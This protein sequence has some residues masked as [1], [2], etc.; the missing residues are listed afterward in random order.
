MSYLTLIR[1]HRRLIG[2]GFLLALFSSF[3][4]T[5]FISIFNADIRSAYGLSQGGFGTIYSLATLTSAALVIR[6][7]GLIDR[8][9]LRRYSLGILG[10]LV[11]AMAYMSLMPALS[12]LLLF[13][14]ILLLRFFG[15]GLT[16]QASVIVVSRYIEGGRGKAIALSALGYSTGEALLPTLTVALVGLL[17]W[18]W[19]WGA[20]ALVLAAVALPLVIWLLRGQERR[21]AE[22]MERLATAPAAAGRLWGRRAVLRDPFFQLLLP[23]TLALGFINTGIFFCQVPLVEAKGWSLGDFAAAVAV[24]AG[25]SVATS[26]LAGPLVDRL[27]PRRLFPFVLLP[28]TFGLLLL[29]LSEHRLAIVGFMLAAGI[30]G[31]F[32]NPVASALWAET[33]GV[34]NLGAIRGMIGGLMVLATALSPAIMGLL[35]DAGVAM[36]TLVLL[37]AGY[38]FVAMLLVPL[39]TRRRALPVLPA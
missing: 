7:G 24:Y 16:S 15:Q 28:I 30:S 31:G 3:G 39:A 33:Y 11:L 37:C 25:S 2:Y 4:Q 13:P 36:N 8:L 27:G 38:A 9:P 23:A 18:R 14:A 20:L 12:P 34:A 1:Q 17:G 19:T 21:H 5:Y 26:L 6:S 22:L 10:G 29:A 32:F 35:L